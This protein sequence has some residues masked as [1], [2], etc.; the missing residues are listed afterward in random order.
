MGQVSLGAIVMVG[1]SVEID[2]VV[3]QCVMWWVDKHDFSTVCAARVK[4]CDEAYPIPNP[5]KFASVGY[6]NAN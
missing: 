3:T 4:R 5:V 2:Y 6:D 1:R